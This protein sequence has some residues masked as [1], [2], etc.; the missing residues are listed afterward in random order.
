M[1]QFRIHLR[2]TTIRI[3]PFVVGAVRDRRLLQEL[4]LMTGYEIKA[5]N[6]PL[7]DLLVDRSMKWITECCPFGERRLYGKSAIPTSMT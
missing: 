3:A 1:S 4:D 2:S 7:S 5:D 6:L